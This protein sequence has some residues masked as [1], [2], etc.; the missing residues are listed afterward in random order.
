MF[1]KANGAGERV[2]VGEG[3]AAKKVQ[4]STYLYGFFYS[5]QPSYYQQ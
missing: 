1:E 2:A 3:L 5:A 4:R